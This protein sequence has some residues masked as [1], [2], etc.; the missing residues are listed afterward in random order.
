LLKLVKEL[1]DGKL[2]IVMGGPTDP[3]GKAGLVGKLLMEKPTARLRLVM[4]GDRYWGEF[5]PD[6]Q[7]EFQKV[8]TGPLP[9]PVKD[10]ISIQCY[11]GPSEAEHWMR[12]DEFRILKL[13][14]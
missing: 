12:F 13:A 7:G 14:E 1:I 6:A 5:Q 11:Q 8:G 3:D 2:Y 4:S 10:Q 9:P